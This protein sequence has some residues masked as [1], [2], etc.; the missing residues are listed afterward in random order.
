MTQKKLKAIISLIGVA[1]GVV[2]IIFGLTV[3]DSFYGTW[4]DSSVSFGGDFYTYVYKAAARAG[5]NVS[6]LGDMLEKAFGFVL[7]AM[8]MFDICYF[9]LKFADCLPEEFAIPAKPAAPAASAEPAASVAPA[10][11]VSSEATLDEL[12]E[13]LDM[14]VITQEEFD[15]KKPV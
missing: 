14:G 7:I 9:G 15:A 11:P 2:V 13:L 6:N 8:G 5:N 4:S 1:V 3:L 10:A 12:Q